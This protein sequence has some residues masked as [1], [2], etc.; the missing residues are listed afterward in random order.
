MAALNRADNESGQ[1]DREEIRAQDGPMV[2]QHLAGTHLGLVAL[3]RHRLCLLLQQSTGELFCLLGLL[4]FLL[5]LPGC[6]PFP[7][8]ALRNLNT[9]SR[10]TRDKQGP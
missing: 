6:L 7:D 4:L 10:V 2:A 8:L 1:I 3:L 5:L 9:K